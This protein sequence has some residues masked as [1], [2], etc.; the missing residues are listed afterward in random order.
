MLS[1]RAPILQVFTS[2]EPRTLSFLAVTFVV[3]VNVR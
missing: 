2:P 1:R 3:S